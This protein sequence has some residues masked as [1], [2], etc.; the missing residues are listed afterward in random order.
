LLV[1]SASD[2]QDRIFKKFMFHS[3]CRCQM[4]QQNMHRLQA[5]T[6]L[7]WYQLQPT[8]CHLLVVL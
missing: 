6:L 2:L 4:Q 8:C 3:I 7:A 1:E 5:P